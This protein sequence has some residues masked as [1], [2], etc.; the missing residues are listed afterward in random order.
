MVNFRRFE[1]GS[2]LQLF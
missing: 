2:W 1:L